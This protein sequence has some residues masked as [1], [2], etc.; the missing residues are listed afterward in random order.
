MKCHDQTNGSTI[1][2]LDIILNDFGISYG[3]ISETDLLGSGYI[4]VPPDVISASTISETYIHNA[5]IDCSSVKF[6][7]YCRRSTKV[8]DPNSKKRN[9]IGS[10]RFTYNSLHNY[11]CVNEADVSTRLSASNIQSCCN[12]CYCSISTS[13]RSSD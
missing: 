7:P 2:P 5:R 13:L 8:F 6:K 9:Y 10:I 1:K 3:E 4:L 12:A 11:S